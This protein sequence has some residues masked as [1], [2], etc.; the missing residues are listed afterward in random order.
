MALIAHHTGVPRPIAHRPAS[1]RSPLV[2]LAGALDA[3][4]S[5]L[6]DWQQRARERRQLL[7][8]DDRALADLG[9]SRVDAEAEARK[10]VWKP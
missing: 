8:L 4:I 1:S 3:G 7:A 2:R 9:R 10:P 5:A 6:L